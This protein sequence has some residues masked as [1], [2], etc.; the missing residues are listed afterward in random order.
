MGSGNRNK[1]QRTLVLT[2]LAGGG[3]AVQ[4]TLQKRPVPSLP[5]APLVPW[6]PLPWLG[7][8]V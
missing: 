4:P 3:L 8:K 1:P 2:V 7:G 5:Q 6:H